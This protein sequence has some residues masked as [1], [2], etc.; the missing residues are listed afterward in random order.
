MILITG[1]FG[2]LGNSLVKEIKNK[3][4]FFIK[5]GNKYKKIAH[6]VVSLN[7]NNKNHLKKL[8]KSYKFS[9][10]IHLA[11]TR[12]PLKIKNIRDTSTLIKDTNI[13]INFLNEMRNIK[14]IILA[15]SV[16]IF[17]LRSLTDKI[18]RR[19]IIKDINKFL[20]NN[21]NNKIIIKSY[22]K[23][24][25][26]KLIN[27]DPLFHSNKNM[28][29]NGS[30]KLINEILFVNYA[31]ENKIKIMIIRPSTIIETKKERK[32]LQLKIKKYKKLN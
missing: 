1:G 17:K 19:L 6:N 26:K 31:L 20:N 14:K 11:V 5:R 15:S 10:L 29:L 7:L 28:R 8:F 32:E 9:I 4:I 13:S 3:K 18:D 22:F 27:I 16:S 25:R 23:K 24:K 12:N 2:K 30:N 21:N